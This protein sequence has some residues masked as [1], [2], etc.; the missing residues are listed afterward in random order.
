M[1]V[2]PSDPILDLPFLTG[3]DTARP[4][5]QAAIEVAE[6]FA[7][8]RSPVLRYLLTFDLPV[9]DGEEVLQEV[10]L[11][12]FQHLQRGGG[13]SHLRGWVFRVAY[14][15]ALKW[16]QEN[17]RQL[18]NTADSLADEHHDPS[19]N[20]EQQFA[21]VQHKA[22]IRAVM[23]ALPEID[24]GCLALRAEGLRYREIAEI[25]GM[26]LGAVSQSLARSLARFHQVNK[27]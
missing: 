4:C 6:L 2:P 1:Q 26:S 11:A 17:Q 21:F 9:H 22:R 23:R 18:T 19:L 7:Q 12:L 3:K 13:R 15:L 5:P 10:F 8:L 16:R 24:R 14:N 20:P 27:G 25:L